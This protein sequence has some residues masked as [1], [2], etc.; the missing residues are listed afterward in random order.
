MSDINVDELI[1]SHK[2]ILKGG[3]RICSKCS[4]DMENK[5]IRMSMNVNYYVFKC[6]RCGKEEL[7]YKGPANYKSTL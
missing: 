3:S 6:P 7:V 5:G 4:V 1:E 2:K